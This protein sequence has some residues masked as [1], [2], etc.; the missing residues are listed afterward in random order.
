M[1][2]AKFSKRNLASA[3]DFKRCWNYFLTISIL[4]LI[5]GVIL[6]VNPIKDELSLSRII[7]MSLGGRFEYRAI[8]YTALFSALGMLGALSSFG[9]LLSKKQTN[10]YLSMGISRKQLFRNRVISFAIHSAV[11]IFIFMAI[12]VVMNVRYFGFS[13][14]IIQ[15]GFIQ[16][17]ALY[18]SSLIGF[19][20]GLAAIFLA[21]NIIEFAVFAGTLYALPTMLFHSITIVL[22]NVLGTFCV[23]RIGP[24]P[25]FADGIDALTKFSYLNPLTFITKIGAKFLYDDIFLHSSSYATGGSNFEFLSLDYIAPTLAWLAISFVII[26][27]SYRLFASR[28]AEIA[29]K[30]GMNNTLALFCAIAISLFVS[31]VTIDYTLIWGRWSLAVATILFI[32]LSIVFSSLLTLNR[33]KADRNAR[34]II[35]LG[36]ALCAL[37]FVVSFD[38]IGYKKHI[39]EAGKIE[40]AYISVEAD[41]YISTANH[42]ISG[43][44]SGVIYNYKSYNTIGPI[45]ADV[46]LEKFTEVVDEI[47]NCEGNK[48]HCNVYVRFDMADGKTIYRNYNYV[49][50]EARKSILSLYDG[51][52]RDK[53]IDR[54]LGYEEYEPEMFNR[55][56][57]GP[58][59]AR[60]YKIFNLENELWVCEPISEEGIQLDKVDEELRAA[61]R[62][63]LKAQTAQQLFNPTEPPVAVID[64]FKR[65]TYSR[66][67]GDKLFVYK[68]MT[69]TLNYLEK[70]GILDRI[71]IYKKDVYKA[72]VVSVKDYDSAQPN[73][74]IERDMRSPQFASR[75]EH[76]A[77]YKF[78]A[79]NERMSEIKDKKIIDELVKNSVHTYYITNEEGYYVRLWFEDGLMVYLYLPEDKLPE[80][81]K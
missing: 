79:F 61:L 60:D 72:D 36:A 34:L 70:N 55:G 66:R 69:N 65:D 14:I 18:T 7:P 17:L 80:A 5:A 59:S 56:Y 29:G 2:S 12:A 40:K 57:K 30:Y 41:D 13:W 42:F 10:M 63:D 46:D 51:Q 37:L 32:G 76:Y 74:S 24:S 58:I 45:E 23:G 15:H 16:L 9:L 48:K 49:T 19:G 53:Q 8:I 22:S 35:P 20:I 1:T 28:K 78:V 4:M 31:I 47:A 75:C 52:W 54:A 11:P 50:E 43:Y 38:A 33:K 77:D 44:G 39:P 62:I 27:F 73:F 81:L 25:D 64:S 67:L 68:Y 26:A 71:E 3:Y 21:G 6:F